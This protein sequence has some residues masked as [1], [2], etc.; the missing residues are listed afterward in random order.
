MQQRN[1]VLVG[2]ATLT[3]VV[4]ASIVWYILKVN[5]DDDHDESENSDG[6]ENIS[7]LDFAD[8][9]VREKCI[10][11][12]GQAVVIIQVPQ[13]VV[14][15]IIGKEG[16]NI[17]QL[18]S[19]FGVR[20]N[21]D[22]SGEES[23]AKPAECALEIRGQRDKVQ[24][25]EFKI[26]TIIAETKKQ[27]VEDL[28]VPGDACGR[29]IGKGGQSIREMCTISG[30]KINLE[31][32]E[33]YS[34]G[35]QRRIVISGSTEQVEYAKLLIKE[36][37]EQAR[38]SALKY[39]RKVDERRSNVDVPSIARSL[40]LP[41][42][43][44]YFQ[45]FVS[46][47][48]NPNDFWVQMV[49]K[50]SSKLDIMNAEINEVYSKMDVD[51]GRLESGNVGEM[52]IAPFDGD[53]F[54]AVVR[55][56]NKDCTAEVLFIDYGD[57]STVDLDEIK[58]MR[59][60]YKEMYP[61]AVH[62]RLAIDP[63]TDGTWTDELCCEFIELSHCAQWKP[64]MCKVISRNEAKDNDTY[65]VQLVDTSN[66]EDIDVAATLDSKHRFLDTNDEIA[67]KSES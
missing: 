18:R 8:L 58:E 60:E 11:S 29:I 54:R 49:S 28:Y 48:N 13:H 43:G 55:K 37:V 32:E 25:A 6:Q 3:A 36:K 52:C 66:Q 31:R 47:A 10:A 17:K 56:I 46:S 45:V 61:Q 42:N 22:R 53:M 44:E 50:E 19:Q 1:V 4:L 9:N 16:S 14:G 63:P 7:E 2:G 5:E 41:C 20:F 26:N 24:L 27:N 15:S 40:Q 23:S 35:N 33:N 12:A 57:V 21:F 38:T 64:I 67:E 51:E 62:C 30:A 39:G 34:L 65:V 59:F